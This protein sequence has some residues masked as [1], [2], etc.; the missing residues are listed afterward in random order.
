[1]SGSNGSRD[2]LSYSAVVSKFPIETLS[3]KVNYTLNALIPGDKP[4]EKRHYQI[5]IISSTGLSP[6]INAFNV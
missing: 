1:M 5:Q 2:P 4:V 6:G 3:Q